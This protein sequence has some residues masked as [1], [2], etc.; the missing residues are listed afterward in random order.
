MTE[1]D[2]YSDICKYFERNKAKYSSLAWEAKY[3]SGRRINFKELS[4]HQEEKL[5][6]SKRGYAYKIPDTANGGKKPFDGFFIKGEAVVI[7]V[8]GSKKHAY[9]IDIW[10][11]CNEAYGSDTKSLTEDRA[12]Q[13]GVRIDL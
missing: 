3:T 5:L 10:D 1:A 13:I 2:F 7:V 8:Y 9:L 6:A 11:W 4:A 12:A